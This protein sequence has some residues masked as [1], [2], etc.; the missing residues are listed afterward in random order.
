MGSRNAMR[1]EGFVGI[2][3]GGDLT[4]NGRGGGEDEFAEVSQI[5][6]ARSRSGKDSFGAA[7]FTIQAVWWGRGDSS[8]V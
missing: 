3:A 8:S 5:E 6:R 7:S 4:G 2:D 1:G